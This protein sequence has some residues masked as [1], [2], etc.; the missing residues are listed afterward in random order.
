[1]FAESV[2]R[3]TGQWWKLVVGVVAL[4]AGSI[5]PVFES[6]GMS[7][8]VGTVIAVV[9]YGFTL[10]FIK[11]QSCDLRCFWKAL[12]YSEMY[13][14]LFTKSSCPSCEHNF[15]GGTSSE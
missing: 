1:M 8:T 5:V 15:G 11:C 12:L 2:I 7:W 10:A 9:G 4:L 14:P 3:K 13:S 6:V